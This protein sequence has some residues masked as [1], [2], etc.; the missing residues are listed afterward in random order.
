MTVEPDDERS[1]RTAACPKLASRKLSTTARRRPSVGQATGREKGTLEVVLL[2]ARP[3]LT[4][5]LAN[6][7]LR[8]LRNAASDPSTTTLQRSA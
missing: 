4:P 8:L 6:A 7:L 1:V 5:G 3:V 2:V